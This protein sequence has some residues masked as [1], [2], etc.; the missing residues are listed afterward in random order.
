MKTILAVVKGKMDRFIA[1]P[2]LSKIDLMRKEV[3]FNWTIGSVISISFLTILAFVLDADI[4]GIFGLVLI[5]Y[6][7]VEIPLFKR[8]NYH[9]YQAIF[10][11]IIILTAFIFILIFGGITNSAG[12]IF[13]GL[14]CVISSVLMKSVRA[15]FV[16]FFLYISTI[17]GLAIL[18]PYLT[19]HPDI[20]PKINFIYFIINTIWMSG[21]MMFF[22]I[23]YLTERNNYQVAETTRLEELDKAK[24]QLFTSITHEFRTP[25]TLIS[26]M[27]D[28]VNVDGPKT[29]NAVAQIKKQSKKLL[30]LV[31]QIL[32][33]SKIDAK[34]MKMHLI[35]GEII[36]YLKYLVE[37]YHSAA[38][39]KNIRFEMHFEVDK[40]YMDFDPEKLEAIVTNII[41]NA[42]K[43]TAIDGSVTVMVQNVSGKQ[44]EISVKDTGV[45]I[46]MHEC[47]EIFKRYYQIET[48]D[49]KEGN[50]LGLTIVKE[51]V[52]LMNGSVSV[53]SQP[54]IGSVF[55]VLLPIRSNAP[56]Q[57]ID[58]TELASS[59]LEI[60]NDEHENRNSELPLLLIL[61]DHKEILDYLISIL[62][63]QYRII[64][65]ED[66]N[67]GLRKALEQIPDIIVSDVMMPAMDGF[68]FLK[69]IKSDFRTS[70]IPVLMLTAKADRESMLEGLDLGAEAYLV[71]PFDKEELLIRLRK[72]LDLRKIL[73]A[74]YQIKEKHE[75]KLTE[76]SDIED[77]FMLKVQE[78]I[79]EHI[80]DE[81]FKVQVLCQEMAMSRTQFYRKFAALTDITINKYIRRY[82]L[83][84]ASELLR[85]T[86]LNVSQIALEVGIPNLAYFSRIFNDEFNVSPSR[87]RQTK[88]LE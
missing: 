25:I 66:G 39:S 19:N 67:E 49:Y 78:I 57:I 45:G 22:I 62:Q 16:L 30:N 69:Q 8:H 18:D 12:L 31:N 21:A 35:N 40:L 56:R 43:F 73:H 76:S 86:E 7:L 1:D 85:T 11:A 3:A 15:A 75:N 46:P 53:E 51:F 71:K 36:Q 33:L 29:S 34:T 10:L 77:Q 47:Q 65:G 41:S 6:Y 50:G 70:H 42:L 2:D 32:D 23:T 17:L 79:D 82:R 72:L 28:L 9:I 68:E 61:D 88:I 26:G 64:V 60:E 55:T 38:E 14:T 4:I 20:T 13:V 5:V 58:N 48:D 24:S 74:R 81:D 83:R 87:A 59:S 44:L 63:N 37:S 27:A 54:G 84:R 80:D 52:N